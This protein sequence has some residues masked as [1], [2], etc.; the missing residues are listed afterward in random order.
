MDTAIPGRVCHFAYLESAVNGHLCRYGA[1]PPAAFFRRHL[2][3]VD[4]VAPTLAATSSCHPFVLGPSP[5]FLGA[6]ALLNKQGIPPSDVLYR[7]LASAPPRLA[8]LALGRG[9][10]FLSAS[11]V[12]HFIQTEPTSPLCGVSGWRCATAFTGGDTFG[13]A[14]R[15][16]VP[17]CVM[18]A[19]SEVRRPV[20]HLHICVRSSHPTLTPV[21]VCPRSPCGASVGSCLL[22][23]V[24]V[25]AVSQAPSPE[26]NPN[27]PLPVKTTVSVYITV[28]S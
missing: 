10:H 27:S 6:R 24:E 14:L 7:T 17:G 19:A 8:L 3:L 4:D 5:T 23:S 9:V 12:L 1:L 11:A 21:P 13:A 28:E 16:H 15:A 25:V 20:L 2:P 18:L 22:P 26:S